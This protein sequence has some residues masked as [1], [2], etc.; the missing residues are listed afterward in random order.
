MAKLKKK[1]WKYWLPSEYGSERERE[2]E[3]EERGERR[4]RGGEEN[5]NFLQYLKC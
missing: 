5:D 4:E 3:R 2:R 1:I